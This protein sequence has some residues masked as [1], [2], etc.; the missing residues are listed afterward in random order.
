[1]EHILY[2]SAMSDIEKESAGA[3]VHDNTKTPGT[4]PTTV[5]K[6]LIDLAI[7]EVILHFMEAGT[8]RQGKPLGVSSIE[9][10]YTFQTERPAD[11]LE[12]TSTAI[13]T[14]SP[15]IITCTE[16]QRKTTMWFCMRWVGSTPKLKG[17]WSEFYSVDII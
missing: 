4:A 2:N 13:A 9:L 3:H 14:A 6:V 12:F 8:K 1:M 5:P 7:R 17:P 16:A 11:I 15:L 10:V